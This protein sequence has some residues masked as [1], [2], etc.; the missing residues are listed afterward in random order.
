M[1]ASTPVVSTIT[2]CETHRL[3]SDAGHTEAAGGKRS[4]QIVDAPV[5]REESPF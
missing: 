4:A 3:Q 5:V 1:V 2:R